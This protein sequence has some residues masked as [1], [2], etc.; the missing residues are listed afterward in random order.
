M[1]KSVLFFALILLSS[2]GVSQSKA[3]N[4]IGL[5][6]YI[7]AEPYYEKGELDFNIAPLV[8]QRSITNNFDLRLAS[9]LNLGFR[10]D[11]IA[12]TH[13]GLQ[14]GGP[15][16]FS[17]KENK[18]EHSKGLYIAPVL[19]LTRN[20]LELHTNTGLYIEPGYHLALSDKFS[21]M[22]GLELGATYF[23]YDDLREDGWESHFGVSII[24]AW[25]I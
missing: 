4:Y 22:M 10:N 18:S 19:S 23:N 11:E 21:L 3:Y 17:K 9:I 7:T 24:L 8:Y 14:L 20:I 25:S 1:R 16:Y 12:I 5:R 2:I 13:I 15:I 6:P